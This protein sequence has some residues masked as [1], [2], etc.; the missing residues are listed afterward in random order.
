MAIEIKN[1]D[2]TK[3]IEIS[4]GTGLMTSSIMGFLVDLSNLK[5]ELRRERKILSIKMLHIL[6][7]ISM[8]LNH[9]SCGRNADVSYY[10]YNYDY[11]KDFVANKVI[12]LK[13][14]YQDIFTNYSMYM[15]EEQLDVM[16]E[17]KVSIASVISLSSGTWRES[18]EKYENIIRHIYYSS[19][20]KLRES[21]DP[22]IK[23]ARWYADEH[24][25]VLSNYKQDLE[26]FLK[27]FEFEKKTK[28]KSA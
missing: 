15:N 26:K 21:N 16:G 18:T 4:I 28:G 11:L 27:A 20:Y 24:V 10:A 13:T 25:R 23:E 3:N 9:L 2:D 14:E 19:E 1:D 17:L 22:M 7:M 5:I 12:P 8:Q 6:N